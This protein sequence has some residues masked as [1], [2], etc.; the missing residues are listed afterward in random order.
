MNLEIKEKQSNDV[1]VC[2]VKGEININTSPNM[3]KEFEKL[4]REDSKKILLNLNNVSYI[5]SSGLA[6]LIE[7]LQRVKRNNG[8][9][10]LSN[11]SE[12]VS[13]LFEITKLDKL[14]NIFSSEEEALQ[15][16]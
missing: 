5:D 2:S 8:L 7:I 9:M 4:V 1:I 11:L 14:F 12:K 16:F 15:N 13:S 6:T 3:R 10:R